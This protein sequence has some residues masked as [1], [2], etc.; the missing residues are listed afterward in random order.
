MECSW[1]I[2]RIFDPYCGGFFFVPRGARRFSDLDSA[3]IMGVGVTRIGQ[4]H[5]R[6]YPSINLN[7][8]YDCR[9]EIHASPG[10]HAEISPRPEVRFTSQSASQAARVY[11]D[12][13]AAQHSPVLLSILHTLP[14]H[15]M[16]KQRVT[17]NDLPLCCPPTAS[18]SP[19][20]R[21]I[22]QDDVSECRSAWNVTNAIET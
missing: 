20:T 14:A 4:L 8:K 10:H 17:P 2:T 21:Q 3:P 19:L 9:V 6:S 7:R 1:Y 22:P 18:D 11:N 13:S 12:A 16:P 15:I 5:F